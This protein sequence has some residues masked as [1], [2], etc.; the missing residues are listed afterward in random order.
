MPLTTQPSSVLVR[1][2]SSTDQSLVR[3]SSQAPSRD[4]VS[5]QTGDPLY[6]LYL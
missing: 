4:P 2:V 5:Y 3:A 1:T 6:P